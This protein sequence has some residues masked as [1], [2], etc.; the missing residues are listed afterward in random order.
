MHCRLPAVGLLVLCGCLVRRAVA[1]PAS[2]V[3]SHLAPEVNKVIVVDPTITELDLAAENTK[4][5]RQRSA[6]I[7]RDHKPTPY[8]RASKRMVIFDEGLE[9]VTS[10]RGDS[11]VSTAVSSQHEHEAT[12]VKPASRASETTGT[13]HS[14]PHTA[15]SSHHKTSEVESGSKTT[16]YEHS[17][18]TGVGSGSKTTVRGH[19]EITP[20]KSGAQHTS[21]LPSHSTVQ[22]NS[23]SKNTASGHEHTHTAG[24]S[25]GAHYTSIPPHSTTGVESASKITASKHSKT[26]EVNS[27][28]PYGSV[29]HH[30]MTEV[31]AESKTTASE[32]AK[33]T[34]L[35]SGAHDGHRRPASTHDKA[36]GCKPVHP[37]MPKFLQGWTCREQDQLPVLEESE[38]SHPKL[39][40]FWA[41]EGRVKDQE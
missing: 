19:P 35:R 36:H 17:H 2:G 27:G 37:W 41:H 1:L 23:Q 39:I 13:K 12:G 18:T 9:T 40:P 14:T 22:V 24:Y 31:E 10:F 11:Q 30:S 8:A 34:G 21:V 4:L 6:G 38:G 26:T 16:S 3:G 20:I 7:E 5:P 25:S 28:S 33:S 15:V 29:S 32:H